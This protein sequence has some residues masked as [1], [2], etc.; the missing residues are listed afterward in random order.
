MKLASALAHPAAVSLEH[1]HE[2]VRFLHHLP[3][4][5][6]NFMSVLANLSYESLPDYEH[7][8]SLLKKLGSPTEQR[9]AAERDFS[10]LK[11]SPAAQDPWR[12]LVSPVQAAQP[13]E[14]KTEAILDSRAS[15]SESPQFTSEP[16]S[17]SDAQPSHMVTAPAEWPESSKAA[18]ETLA[19]VDP[20]LSLTI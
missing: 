5:M 18:T 7:L 3:K 12:D 16:P 15:R 8:R 11:P 13:A 6:I 14:N 17:P 1:F 9:L 10:H 20:H 4:P 2:S 19:V